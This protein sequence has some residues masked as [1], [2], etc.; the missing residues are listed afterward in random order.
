MSSGSGG[1]MELDDEF[2]LDGYFM[3][4]MVERLEGKLKKSQK[5]YSKS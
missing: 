5:K 3:E 2:K 4:E 1:D